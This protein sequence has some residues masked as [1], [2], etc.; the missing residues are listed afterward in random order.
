VDS[1]GV[2]DL[3]EAMKVLKSEY[4]HPEL[5]TEQEMARAAL[6]GLL[7][8]LGAGAVLAE[9]GGAA[10]AAPGAPFLAEI[11]DDRIG[12][13]RLGALGAESINQLDAALDN[14]RGKGLGAV[15]LDL[16]FTPYSGDFDLALEVARRFVPQGRML[17]SVRKPGAKQERM[18]TSSAEPRFQGLVMVLADAETAGSPEVIAAALRGQTR[19]LVV[20]ETTAGRAAEYV[21]RRLP[22]GRFLRFAVAEAAL[23]DGTAIHPDGVRPDLAVKLDPSVKRRIATL[24]G[25]RGISQ[26]VFEKERARMNEAAL[27]AGTNPELDSIQAA[28]REG[29]AGQEPPLRDT[30][31]QRAV[32]LITTITIYETKPGRQSGNATAKPAP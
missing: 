7:L 25:E 22:G 31:L 5:L 30:V 20:G 4:V 1:L 23:P 9:S 32:D 12:Y 8:R 2:A 24:S 3:Q 10:P 6:E 28:R 15:V 27:V 11:L 29:E 14:F 16:R 13:V 26:F 21:E 17:F 18:F 19:A